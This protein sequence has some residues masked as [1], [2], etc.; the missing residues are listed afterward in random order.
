MPSLKNKEVPTVTEPEEDKIKRGKR[1]KYIREALRYSTRQ[2]HIKHGVSSSTLRNWE[3]GQ[4]GGLTADGAIKL[5]AIFQKEGVNCTFDWL[6][7]G[8]GSDPIPKVNIYLPAEQTPAQS[9]QSDVPK[10]AIT[11]ELSMFHQLHAGAIDMIVNDDGMEPY[12]FQGDWVAGIRRF[13]NDINKLLGLYCIVQTQ[14]GQMLVRKLLKGQ[15]I[16][17]YK[18]ACINPNATINPQI[19]DEVQLVGAAHV[20][21]VRR[22]DIIS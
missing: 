20:I 22:P 19:L 6:Y 10:N 14:A 21:W 11:Q 16:G 1:I 12:C 17:Y 7:Y 5:V 18:L 8:K 3:S 13:G 2:F 4:Y 9:E 15:Q